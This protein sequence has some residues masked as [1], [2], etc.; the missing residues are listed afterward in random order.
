M[1]LQID[2]QKAPYRRLFL[3]LHYN[4]PKNTTI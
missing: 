3:R 2:Q 4:Q 1:G